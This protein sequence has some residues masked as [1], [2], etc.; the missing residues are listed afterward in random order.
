M[1]AKPFRK[2]ILAALALGAC[3]GSDGDDET[4][5]GG[6]GG[7][8]AGAV[9]CASATSA[10]DGPTEDAV[11]AGAASLTCYYG[12]P[13]EGYCREI[14]DPAAVQQYD[15]GGK[16]AIGCTDAV[17]VSDTPCPTL[18]SRGRC[19]NNTIEAARVYYACSKFP[20]PAAHCAQ[21]GGTFVA[22]AGADEP[23]TGGGGAEP[24]AG[25]GG[26]SGSAT[27]TCAELSDCCASPMMPPDQRPSCESFI[28]GGEDGCNRAL[29]TYRLVN[30]CPGP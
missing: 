17:V 12:Q 5:G 1:H 11:A 8:G 10:S 19:E 28:G 3:G 24:P 9:D 16:G 14:T 26:G 7:G 4:D 30:W 23:P 2:M 25:G 15:S 29:A 18:N 6:A 22:P 13:S 21:I 20:D 27:G